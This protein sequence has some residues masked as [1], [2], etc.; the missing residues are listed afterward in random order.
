MFQQAQISLEQLSQRE[1][2]ALQAILNELE[3]DGRS[4]LLEEVWQA[5]YD[6]V[7]V[8]PRKFFTDEFY[9]GKS[10]T[11][12][13]PLWLDELDY[14]LDPNHGIIEWLLCGA[15]GIGKTTVAMAAQ[16]YKLYCL[17]C[18]KDPA[19]FYSLLPG[20][21]ITFG[22]FNIT[23]D[24]ADTGYDKL[25]YWMREAP[26]FKDVVPMCLRPTD[27]ITVPSKRLKVHVGSSGEHALG[28]DMFGYVLDEA[29]FF[30][31]VKGKRGVTSNDKTRAHDIYMQAKRRQISRFMRQGSVPGLCCLMGSPKTET[32]F[33]E[34]RKTRIGLDPTIHLTNLALWETKS[35]SIYSGRRFSVVVGDGREPSRVL[36]DGE[37]LS[38]DHKTVEVP[39]EYKDA[40]E[41][42][43]DDALRDL[44]GVAVTASGRFFARVDRIHACV[45]T[46]RQHPFVQQ[47]IFELSSEDPDADLSEFLKPE[48]LFKTAQSH[49][50]AIVDPWAQRAAHVDIGLTG[51]SLGLAVGH[52][53]EI[54]TLYF[55]I[56]LRINPPKQGEVDLDA[57]V[58]FF[59]ELRS[60]GLKIH[61]VT[62]DGYQS[63][64]SIQ[65]LKKVG[66]EAGLL[67]IGLNDYR[68]L[69]RRIY[70]GPTACS[71]YAYTPLLKELVELVKDPAGGNPDHPEQGSNDVADAAA[72]VCTALEGIANP[73]A[74]YSDSTTR[75]RRS[76]AMRPQIGVHP[77]DA[78]NMFPKVGGF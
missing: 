62:Y 67:S 37:I 66:F 20:S 48:L 61:S 73:M 45:D 25:K 68:A 57:I 47:E 59:R 34:E 33:L 43:T 58:K 55:D 28:D 69:R 22:I 54:G 29:N 12:L 35:T 49:S 31:K 17:T 65:Q 10:L 60:L 8:T 7:P 14:V 64:Q 71:Y 39:I 51:D 42:D 32:E 52:L 72:G 78:F 77:T 18:L 1:R 11:E 70:T 76:H 46:N 4:S 74:K 36:D 63:K 13:H 19:S 75:L 15:I 38:S 2:E 3:S 23:L 5:D 30:K 21:T 24:K 44:A 9:F 40:F 50:Q 56:L 16:G 53:T 26:Y 27:P 6:R 41:E